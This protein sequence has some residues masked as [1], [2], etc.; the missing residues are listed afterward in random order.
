MWAGLPGP[1]YEIFCTAF[2]TSSIHAGGHDH[3]YLLAVGKLLSLP[4]HY[5]LHWG[6]NILLIMRAKQ[7]MC[8][9]DCPCVH[10]GMVTTLR[11]IELCANIGS[12]IGRKRH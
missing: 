11:T 12:D 5:H 9:G 10:S 4:S 2:T 6:E 7:W 8:V 3:N 1:R